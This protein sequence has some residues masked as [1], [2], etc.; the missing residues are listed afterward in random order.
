MSNTRQPH[1]IRESQNTWSDSETTQTSSLW[2]QET[3]R[4]RKK[5]TRRL[6]SHCSNGET[7]PSAFFTEV[8]RR[9]YSHLSWHLHK[10]LVYPWT[11]LYPRFP[12]GFAGLSRFNS[13]GL[14]W[15]LKRTW[16]SP[17]WLWGEP[18]PPPPSTPANQRVDDIILWAGRHAAV[19]HPQWT[20]IA[21]LSLSLC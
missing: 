5:K 21:S 10:L 6:P 14:L 4:A 15:K 16:I 11:V 19:N 20:E 8:K 12:T 3:Q 2:Y 18:R 7:V 17:H 9:L 1:R 13:P